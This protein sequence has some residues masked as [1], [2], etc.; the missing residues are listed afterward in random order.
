MRN[1]NEVRQL[2]ALLVDPRLDGLPRDPDK[3]SRPGLAGR[4]HIS[5]QTSVK[6]NYRERQQQ[7][8]FVHGSFR[9]AQEHPPPTSFLL[10]PPWEREGCTHS[11][12]VPNI[13]GEVRGEGD[14]VW[15]LWFLISFCSFDLVQSLAK[16]FCSYTR[17]KTK[18]TWASD[19]LHGGRISCLL[20]IFF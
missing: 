6:T 18:W 13:L 19:F 1:S 2:A 7:R 12:T 4:I 9:L 14:R 17:S 11:P 8:P 5:H 16:R 15:G 10:V 20:S 3:V